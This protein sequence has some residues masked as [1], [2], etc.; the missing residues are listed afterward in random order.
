[1]AAFSGSGRVKKARDY[2]LVIVDAPATGHGVGFLQTTR[3]FAGIARVAA[4]TYPLGFFDINSL[5]KFQ[6]QNPGQKVQA[7]L[8][9]YDK[10]AFAIANSMKNGMR[11]PCGPGLPPLKLA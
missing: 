7:I 2:D 10:P 5:V 1:M 9:M 8:M 11:S 3:T 4:G 6:D